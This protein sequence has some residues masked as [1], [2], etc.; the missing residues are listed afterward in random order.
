MTS[1]GDACYSPGM[2]ETDIS[3]G[4]QPLD[5]AVQLLLGPAE[6][7][8][9]ACLIEKEITTPEYYPLTLKALTAACNQKSNRDPVMALAESDVSE[10]LESLRYTHHLAWQV[11]SAGSRVS[12]YKHGVLDTFAFNPQELAVMCELMLRGPQTQGE[13]R[14]HCQ[15]MA[16]FESVDQVRDIAEGLKEWGGTRLVVQLP[17]GPGRREPRY[18]HLLCGSEGLTEAGEPLYGEVDPR[19][20]AAPSREARIDTLEQK[21]EQL[22]EQLNALHARFDSFS[23]QFE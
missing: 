4:E 6:V 2:N 8:V 21:V 20:P 13:L 11:S 16:P 10:A 3:G 5:D 12:K 17:P 7:R 1:Q 23:G 22:T 9:L 14:T 18:A 15:R 19:A